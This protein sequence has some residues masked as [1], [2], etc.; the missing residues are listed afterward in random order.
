MSRNT[1][2]LSVGLV[3]LLLPTSLLIPTAVPVASATTPVPAALPAVTTITVNGELS[4][5]PVASSRGGSVTA[6]FVAPAVVKGRPVILQRCSLASVDPAVCAKWVKVGST[7]KMSSTGVALFRVTPKDGVTYRASASKYVHKVGRK[8]VTEPAVVSAEKI[9]ASDWTKVFADEFSGTA[10]DLN[11][12]A[13]TEAGNY[14]ATN[15]YCSAPADANSTVYKGQANLKMTKVTDKAV[16]AQV[17]LNARAS[18]KAAGLPEVGCPKGV[19]ANAHMRTRDDGFTIK[20]GIVA[21]EVT[22][23]IYQ[24]MH[25]GVWLYSNRGAEIDMVEAFGWRKG[26]QAVLHFPAG[27]G[28]EAYD[29]PEADKWINKGAI[30]KSSWWKKSHV[31]S[32]E[33]T[34]SEVIWRMDGVVTKRAIR[35]LPDEAYHI[36]MSMLSSDWETGRLTRPVNGG[37]KAPSSTTKGTLKVNWVRAWT[38]VS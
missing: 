3:S 14:R 34:R 32:V 13:Y 11:T 37:K 17:D 28:L 9:V 23:P 36:R 5:N 8:K 4:F 31:F 2:V 10:F 19:F 25:S 38:A 21:A 30:A 20:Q 6:T 16:I 26:A 33:F 35:D 27:S 22:F 15:R 1:R 7:V 18:Q 24:G 12:W 29:T